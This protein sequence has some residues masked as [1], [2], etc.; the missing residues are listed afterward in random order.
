MTAAKFYT[1]RETRPVNIKTFTVTTAVDRDYVMRL[2]PK[3]VLEIHRLEMVR[4][5]AEGLVNA[6]TWE[7]R[8]REDGTDFFVGSIKVVV[9]E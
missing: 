1:I 8:P 4:Q 9:P 7:H 6:I 5:L 2:P 3:D